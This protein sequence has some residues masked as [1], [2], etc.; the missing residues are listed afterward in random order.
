M[1]SKIKKKM[2]KRTFDCIGKEFY[3]FDYNQEKIIYKYVCYKRLKKKQ[4]KCIKNNQRFDSYLQWKQYICNNYKDYSKSKLI[5]FSRYLN[6]RVKNLKPN[7][8]YNNILITVC[9][10]WFVTATLNALVSGEGDSGLSGW[11]TLIYWILVIISIIL[12]IYIMIE[13]IFNN[14]IEE[15]LL[16]DYKEIIDEMLK[17]K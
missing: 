7:K 17:D 11:A 12:I 10:T 13:P 15:D 16:T 1:F 6:Q 9:L 3:N 8:E 4:L 5:N 14:N 2:H